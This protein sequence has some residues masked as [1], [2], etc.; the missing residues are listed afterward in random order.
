MFNPQPKPE[1]RAKKQPK[2]LRKV[3]LKRGKL[4]NNNHFLCSNGEKVTQSV[5]DRNLS[6]SYK[7][8]HEGKLKFVC[9]GCGDQ[10][11]NNSHIIAQARCK[12]LGKTE[13]IWDKNNYFN[14]CMR[15]HTA[16]ESFK[17]GEFV[18]M[19]ITP[20]AMAYLKVN[21][22]EGWQKRISYF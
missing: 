3:A 11:I 7:E 18:D 13:L 14:A 10:A 8:K 6:A 15:C 17:S 19:H 22:L 2:P 5:I 1:K 20:K 4:G 16:W 9:E 12:V 21:D